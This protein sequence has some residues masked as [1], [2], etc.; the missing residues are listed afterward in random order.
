MIGSNLSNQVIQANRVKDILTQ[1]NVSVSIRE[2]VSSFH[3]CCY[4]YLVLSD[5]ERGFWLLAGFNI[6]TR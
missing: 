1:Y 4:Y 3:F 6:R 2:K 5:P